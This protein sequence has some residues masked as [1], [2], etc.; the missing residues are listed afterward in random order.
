MTLEF[1]VSLPTCVEGMAYP[2]R[3][4]DHTGIARV[5]AEAERLGYDSVLVNDHLSTMPYVRAGFDEPPRF[6]EPL[7]TLSYLAARTSTIRLM[8]GVVVVPMRDPVLLAKQA[9]VVD[10]LSGGRLTVGVGVGAYRAEFESVRPDLAAAPRGDLVAE[11]LEA[12]RLL[13]EERVASYEGRYFRFHDVEM[14]PKPAQAPLPLYSSG[15]APG[16]LRRAA[17]LCDGWMPA[18]LPVDRLAAGVRTLREHAEANGRD[19]GALAVAPQMVLCL[20]DDAADA[21]ARFRRSQVYEHLVSLRNTTLKG[22]D[23]D[24]YVS[25]N[26]IGDPATVTDR[27]AALAGAGAGHLAGMIVVANTVDEMLDQMERFAAEVAPAFKGRP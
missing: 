24:A 8:T 11:G 5:A 12:L 17:R 27:I 1:G 10:Q 13:F 6:Y 15:N 18:G 3:F 26:L 19:P 21:V 7:V 9:S 4:A 25:E 14:Y 16:T 23:I 20:G 22:I 2:I